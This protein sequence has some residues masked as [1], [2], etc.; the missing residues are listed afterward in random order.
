[1]AKCKN[2]KQAVEDPGLK[3]EEELCKAINKW[4]RVNNRLGKCYRL[5][6][7]DQII[8]ML[9]DGADTG[10]VGIEC[11]SIFEDALKNDKIYL[12]RLN[13][14]GGGDNPSQVFKHH[15]FLRDTNR[16]GILAIEFRC[17]HAIYLVPHQFFYDVI[18]AGLEYI[19][20]NDVVKNGYRIGSPGD[21]CL[22]MR[23]KCGVVN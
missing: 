15:R 19:T 1:M 10:Y 13:R 20:V 8:D 23:N 22:F 11:K 17:S 21:L 18:T 14:K 16:L 5:H 6:S 7:D 9:I 4:L 3:F 12:D 2:K